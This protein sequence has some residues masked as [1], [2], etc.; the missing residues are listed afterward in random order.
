MVWQAGCLNEE[1]GAQWSERFA[2]GVRWNHAVMPLQFYFYVN[3][4]A[5][6]LR[7]YLFLGRI[8]PLSFLFSHVSALT[9]SW[10]TEG[11]EEG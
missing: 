9:L 10:M 7:G 8:A 11:W 3:R 5:E 2:R 4:R 6:F 1:R